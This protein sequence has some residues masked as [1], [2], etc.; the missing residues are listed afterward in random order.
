MP[1]ECLLR[2]F[3]KGTLDL[4][5]RLPHLPKTPIADHLRSQMVGP[6][7]GYVRSLKGIS[8]I[9][10]LHCTTIRKTINQGPIVRDRQISLDILLA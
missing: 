7:F 9:L 5:A 4:E 1:S 6:A 2:L 3:D 10:N 8:G